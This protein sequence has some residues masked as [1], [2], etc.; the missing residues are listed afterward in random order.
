MR[1]TAWSNY[2]I[3]FICALHQ[4]VNVQVLAST[5][6]PP[7]II[8]IINLCVKN[9]LLSRLPILFKE[10]QCSPGKLLWG[11]SFCNDVKNLCWALSI[12]L[13]T[14]S[15]QPLGPENCGPHTRSVHDAMKK[16]WLPN[17]F[18]VFIMNCKNTQLSGMPNERH[19]RVMFLVWR[20]HTF[21]N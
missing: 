7:K 5:P 19:F 8:F 14:E 12:A 15:P 10:L 1:K 21:F 13:E 20:Q 4:T 3:Y 11:E 6:P 16:H 18:P 9:R 17:W 2:R